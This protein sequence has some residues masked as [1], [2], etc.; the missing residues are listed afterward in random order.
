[1][2]LVVGVFALSMLGSLAHAD[3]PAPEPAAPGP[4]ARIP[5]RVVRVMPDSHQALLYDRER[6]THVLAEVG[7]TVEGYTVESIDDDEVSLSRDGKEVV[8]AAPIY[9]RA[10]ATAHEADG[11][12]APA[13]AAGPAPL[14]PYADLPAA[15]EVRVAHAPDAVSSTGPLPPDPDVHVARAPDAGP[16]RVASAVPTPAAATPATPTPATPA[17]A[18]P[19]TATPATPTPATTASAAAPTPAA[20]PSPVVLGPAAPS[21]PRTAPAP[22][23]SVTLARG[24]LDA[25]LADFGA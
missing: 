18:T 15:G 4:R 2:R 19:A 12:P 6:S 13:K 10:P 21:E 24:E 7:G 20:A 1:M 9:R 8:L 25:A 17:T 23:T 3:N 5:L 22:A 14:D 16:V 11:A